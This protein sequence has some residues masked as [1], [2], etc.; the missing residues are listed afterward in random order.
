MFLT[1]NLSLPH[2]QTVTFCLFTVWSGFNGRQLSGRIEILYTIKV[3]QIVRAQMKV[4]FDKTL[5]LLWPMTLSSRAGAEGLPAL[6][7]PLAGT[8][9]ALWCQPPAGPSP[10][11]SG[12]EW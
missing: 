2:L 9:N 8:H 1:V 4:H 6:Y 3:R 5:L 11:N 12:S 10:E 7:Y